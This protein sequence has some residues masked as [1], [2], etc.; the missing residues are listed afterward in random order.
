MGSWPMYAVFLFL[1]VGSCKNGEQGSVAGSGN[2][3]C[4]PA[5]ENCISVTT[6][7]NT[8]I[9][10]ETFTL[11]L[12]RAKTPLNT[13]FIG[14]EVAGEFEIGQSIIYRSDT[15]VYA[16][17]LPCKDSHDDTLRFSVID[18]YEANDNEKAGRCIFSG[19]FTRDSSGRYGT[20][21]GKL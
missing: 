7:P 14:M 12:T 20:N 16:C 19:Y 10:G 21:Q 4:C 11:S 1:L 13:Q 8:F 15:V 9:C 3:L 5:I 17:F 18:P 6:T 2:T